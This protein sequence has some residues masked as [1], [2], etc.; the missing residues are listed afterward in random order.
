MNKLSLINYEGDCLKASK[1]NGKINITDQWNV[2]VEILDTKTFLNFIDGKM[3]IKDSRDKS[4]N[5]VN[6]SSESK[7]SL[8]TIYDF[9][10]SPENN[11]QTKKCNTKIFKVRLESLDP[12][13]VPTN[14]EALSMEVIDDP[15]CMR[16]ERL[17]LHIGECLYHVDKSGFILQRAVPHENFDIRDNTIMLLKEDLEVVHM[18]LDGYSIPRKDDN[19][20]TYSIVGR[21][22]QF[23]NE[24][25]RQTSNLESFYLEEQSV[26]YSESEVEKL[27]KIQ[28][29]N[30]YV[31]VLNETKDE[32]VAMPTINSP[33]PGM[34]RKTI[35][36]Y[37]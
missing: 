1:V 30:C 9:L 27:L 17:Y 4:W 36:S 18:Y 34:W 31:A 28:R 10:T 2:L 29:G 15:E 33:E 13:G 6:E 5:F 19:G 32:Q 7:P 12:T 11:K 20:E 24:M 22:K 35:E 21:I 23:E 8:S 3:E 25:V 16:H 26:M 14:V 37:E